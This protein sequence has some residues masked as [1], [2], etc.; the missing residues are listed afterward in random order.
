MTTKELG[1]GVVGVVAFVVF[2][3]FL[4]LLLQHATSE[5]TKDDA[6]VLLST[7]SCGW[8]VCRIETDGKAFIVNSKGGVCQIEE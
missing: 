1:V 8:K 4:F 2:V 5:P 6:T 7:E 3:A